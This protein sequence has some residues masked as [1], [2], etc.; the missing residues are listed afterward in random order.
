MKHKPIYFSVFLVTIFFLHSCI[1]EVVIKPDTNSNITVKT[2][3]REN[4]VWS[5]VH[6]LLSDGTS[7]C[8]CIASNTDDDCTMESECKG[9]NT[10]QNYNVALHAMYTD[11][12]I[13]YRST[14]GVRISESIL[15]DALKSDGFPLK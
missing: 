7:G 10:L 11:D 4:I 15:R 12:E 9:S 2:A 6:C 3:K 5:S 1:K 13:T 14:N 8:A